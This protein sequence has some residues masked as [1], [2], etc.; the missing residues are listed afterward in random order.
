VLI[1]GVLVT[2]QSTYNAAISSSSSS[3]H[4]K[5]KRDVSAALSGDYDIDTGLVPEVCLEQS[6][7][8]IMHFILF[9]VTFSLARE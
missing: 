4:S 6:F 8:C 9:T 2:Y 1:G 3:G 7:I 5:R